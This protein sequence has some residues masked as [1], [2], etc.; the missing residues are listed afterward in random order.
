MQQ[1]NTTSYIENKH[2]HDYFSFSSIQ[3]ETSILRK[4][5]DTKS[6]SQR[7][8]KR[9]V[10][11]RRP[12]RTRIGNYCSQHKIFLKAWIVTFLQELRR[13]GNNWARAEDCTDARVSIRYQLNTL[14]SPT[15][16]GRRK[17]E[18]ERKKKKTAC[19][20]VSFIT[21]TDSEASKSVREGNFFF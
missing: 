3:I 14:Q 2:S 18:K 16:I 8:E 7:R 11:N 17:N 10:H 21:R 19:A 5:T 6:L 15:F 9:N 13:L 12:P 20:V 1:A 4:R